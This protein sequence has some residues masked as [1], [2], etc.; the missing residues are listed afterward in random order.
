MLVLL[1]I[2]LDFVM[3]FFS[4]SSNSCL[5]GENKKTTNTNRLEGTEGWVFLPPPHGF[6]IFGPS[7]GLSHGTS[8]RS[9]P[10]PLPARPRS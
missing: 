3:F 6:Q 5:E 1:S 2:L 8:C 10:Q 9:P 4:S 7:L